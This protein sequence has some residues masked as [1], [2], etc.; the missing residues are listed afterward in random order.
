M[1]TSRKKIRKKILGA[2]GS[3]ALAALLVCIISSIHTVIKYK[4]ENPLYV[5]KGGNFQKAKQ[6][7]MSLDEIPIDMVDLVLLKEDSNF[8]YHK[9]VVLKQLLDG[10]ICYVL[11]GFKPSFGF[12][13]IS[14][15]TAKIIF[16]YHDRT[17]VR[18]ILEAYYASL[19]E[20]FWGKARILEV[21]L[22]SVEVGKDL[23]GLETGATHFFS[24]TLSE[25]TLYEKSLFA[26]CLT[27]PHI[28][29]VDQPSENFKQLCAD[30]IDFYEHLVS[31]REKRR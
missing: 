9:G 3:L 26:C 13:T 22:N 10:F 11:N 16:L 31:F 23:Y 30:F 5:K 14:Q 1:E 28:N 21:Y 12:S 25:L 8:F 27:N 19:I 6:Q 20:I 24:R 15:Q 17:I 4:N 18:K 29:K 7:W 2:A